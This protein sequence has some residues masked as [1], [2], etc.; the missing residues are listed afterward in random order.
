MP[1]S[2]RPSP[3]ANVPRSGLPLAMGTS[4]FF[5]PP[6]QSVCPAF[7]LFRDILTLPFQFCSFFASSERASASLPLPRLFAEGSF[8]PIPHGFPFRACPLSGQSQGFFCFFFFSPSQKCVS[9]I[10]PASHFQPEPAVVPEASCTAVTPGL[11]SLRIVL[12]LGCP[13]RVTWGPL[14][15]ADAQAP[16]TPS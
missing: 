9:C 1:I 4:A 2:S 7:S 3:N 12:D 15:F 13:C 8:R 16:V 11:S 14:K 6:R 10:L 5:S